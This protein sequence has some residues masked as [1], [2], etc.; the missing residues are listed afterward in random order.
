VPRPFLSGLRGRLLFL[1]ALATLPAFALSWYAGWESRQHQLAAVSS[2]AVALANRVASD[3][4]VV[5]DLTRQVLSDLAAIPEVRAGEPDRSRAIFSIL[6]KQYR[7]YAGL[8]VLDPAGSILVSQPP[9]VHPV[10]FSA[11]PWFV[12]A[13]TTRRFALGDYQVGQLTGKP[14][15][16]AAWPVID[17]TGR[18]VSV[19]A[20]GLDVTWLN[21]VAAT[22][23][24]PPG[25][26]LVLVDRQGVV[27][28][29]YPEAA[30]VLGRGLPE[31]ALVERMR[32]QGPGTIELADEDGNSRIWAFAAV[33][34]SVPTA[35][36]MAVGVP[37][38]VAY[39]AV[40]RLQRRA[41]LA[42][43]LVMGL[44]LTAAWFAAERFVLRPVSSLIDATRKLAAGDQGA[45]TALPY[46]QSELSDL[47]RSFDE[48]ASALE[49]RQAERDR[50]EQALRSSEE[51]F[52]S[53]MDNSPAIAFVR[54]PGGGL[55]YANA[56]LERAFGLES[57]RW[58]DE[59]GSRFWS[60]ELAERLSRGE[61]QTLETGEPLHSVGAVVL[62]DGRERY[63]LTVTFPLADPGGRML[64]ATMAIDM[65]DWRQA[66]DQLA[67]AERRYSQLVEHA[68][69]AIVITDSGLRLVDVN[70]AT[71]RLTGYTRQELLE[72]RVVDLL[73]PGD[74]ATRPLEIDAVRSGQNV[75][76]ERKVRRKDGT[77]VVAEVSARAFEGGGMQAIVRDVS[78]RYEAEQ[79]VR[80]NEERFRLLYQYLPIAYQSLS[81]HGTI[82][83]VNDAWLALTGLT[84]G[85]AVG[86]RFVDLLAS[87]SLDAYETRFRRAIISD[88]VHDVEL[89]L[90]RGDRGRVTVSIDGRRGQNEHGELRVHCALHDVTAARQADERLRQSEERYRTLFDESPISMWEED[91]S[92]IRRHLDR[93][94]ALG[95]ADFE[96]HLIAHPEELDDCIG[97]VKV[98]DVNRAAL[99]LYG[100]DN[101][102]QLLAGLDRI[103]GEDGRDVFRRSIVALAGGARTWRDE[104][105]NYTLGNQPIRLAL[106]WSIVPG[107]ERTWSR[108][109]VSAVDIT[110]RTRV[111]DALREAEDRFERIFHSTPVLSAISRRSDGILLDVNDVFLRELGFTRGEVV[112]RTW[113]ELGVGLSPDR[114][115]ELQALVDR[116]GAV[117]GQPLR[118]RR[119][120]GGPFEGVLSVVALRVDGE[121]CLLGQAIDVTARRRDEDAA[122]ES[123]RRLAGVLSDLPGMAYQCCVDPEWTMLSVSDGCRALTG[124]EPSDLVGNRLVSY[125]SLIVEDDRERVGAAIRGSIE[126]GQPFRLAYR[127]RHAS[128]DT[129][130]VWEQGRAIEP[131][132]DE[133]TTIE[134]LI[135]DI[136]DGRRAE[137]PRHPGVAPWR[138]G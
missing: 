91:F 14:I 125:G 23:Q 42:L 72:R 136:G 19:L 81:E 130:W 50:A 122:R 84:R 124:Y 28:A 107:A 83:M 32:L 77:F 114:F 51:R 60:P 126:R 96:T 103:I 29:R 9:A 110:G 87:G 16:A 61:A 31:R 95:V 129:R 71:C 106:H 121:E 89:T 76:V 25:A 120:S 30:G 85:Q 6:M 138:D 43:L 11:W 12:Q 33:G 64:A 104:G 94:Q 127:I 111:E 58:R 34:G 118:W 54:A 13:L 108:V 22:A 112:G 41:V 57:G 8:L 109:L 132:R 4:E 131:A 102:S 20:A 56:A 17:D 133:A 26:V 67:L 70:T 100:A 117:H 73:A 88:D 105:V 63:W 24:L 1:I 45:R 101:R 79:T 128:G 75:V 137:A 65:T 35:L 92:G 21:Q 93:L 69:D 53:F 5:I 82:V 68:S 78:A 113:A 80:Q 74:L 86:R 39:G 98:V 38:S 119:R 18:V 47:A 99:A 27:V 44:T 3:Q 36:R 59:P 116:Q 10:N 7:G 90:V 48:M 55:V 40:D 2:D 46:G 49:T 97:A 115:A 62:A 52:R 66:R 135:F 15:V 134:G 123:Q 37:K